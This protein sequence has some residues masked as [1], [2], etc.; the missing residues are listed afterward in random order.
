MNIESGN[1]ER[2]SEIFSSHQSPGNHPS[3]VN[4]QPG[5]GM[6]KCGEC[7]IRMPTDKWSVE[8]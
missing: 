5:T 7:L 8:M 2:C 4:S 3:W 1:I 6:S